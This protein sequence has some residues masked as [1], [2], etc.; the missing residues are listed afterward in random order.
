MSRIRQR[1]DDALDSEMNRRHLIKG[2]ISLTTSVVLDRAN[3]A[4]DTLDVR[5][6]KPKP[7]TGGAS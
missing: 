4:A 1:V 2:A 3:N 5:R 6:P 7:E